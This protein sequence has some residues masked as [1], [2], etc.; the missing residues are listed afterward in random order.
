MS[1]EQ[2]RAA[3]RH[4]ITGFVGSIILTMAAYLTVA[5]NW[6]SGWSA[7][8]LVSLLAVLQLAVQLFFFLHVSA[9]SRPRWKLATFWFMLSIVVVIVGGSLWI[10]HSLNYRMMPTVDEMKQYMQSQNG[11]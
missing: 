10:M 1:E 11:I 8:L 9:G 6:L 7:V 2:A 4:Y 3:L 5:Y